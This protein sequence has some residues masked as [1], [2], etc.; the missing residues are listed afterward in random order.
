MISTGYCQLIGSKEA[1]CRVKKRKE[2]REQPGAEDV[3]E[4]ANQFYSGYFIPSLAKSGI[5][6]V[7]WHG[8]P[9]HSNG[10]FVVGN[11]GREDQ[12]QKESVARVWL[13]Y[14]SACSS[15][16]V[17]LADAHFPPGCSILCAADA[18]RQA[19]S[20]VSQPHTSSAYR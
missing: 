6:P 11:V 20:R 17:A 9:W 1:Y 5:G 19:R 7:K 3:Q 12:R 15:R 13:M 14:I 8:I 16:A 4:L 2:R 10:V 18:P